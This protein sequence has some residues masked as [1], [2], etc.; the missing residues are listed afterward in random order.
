M[1]RRVKY[2]RCCFSKTALFFQRKS[3]K[4]K[5]Y[6]MKEHFYLALVV[7]SFCQTSS[8]FLLQVYLTVF[9]APQSKSCLNNLLLS[10][11]II[12][13]WSQRAWIG[14]T[15]RQLPPDM[16]SR[17]NYGISAS[18]AFALLTSF[19]FWTISLECSNV[20]QTSLAPNLLQNP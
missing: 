10:I 14:Q 3:E 16:C 13:F 12:L 5:I 6:N 20:T 15:F 7:F 9:K 18:S 11:T 4:E 1:L 8:S 19:K 2:Q 17:F